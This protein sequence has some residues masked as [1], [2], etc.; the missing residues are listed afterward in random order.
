MKEYRQNNKGKKKEYD[1]EIRF[2]NIKKNINK[3]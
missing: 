1:E 2:A 3:K